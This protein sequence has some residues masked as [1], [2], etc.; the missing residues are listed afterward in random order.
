MKNKTKLTIGLFIA[1]VMIANMFV[2]AMKIFAS[3]PQNDVGYALIQINGATLSGT[4]GGS[5]VT[6]T[7]EHGT[8]TITGTSLYIDGS[9]I[10]TQGEVSITTSPATDYTAQVWVNGSNK[11]TSATVSTSDLTIKTSA[12]Q[13]VP[14]TNVELVFNAEGENTGITGGPEIVNVSGTGSDEARVQVNE[15][16]TDSNKV[17]VTFGSLFIQKYTGTVTITSNDNAHVY[18][19][20]DYINYSDRDSWLNHYD[21]QT[22]SFTVEGVEKAADDTYDVVVNVVDNNNVFIGNF[23]WTSDP[24]QVD[25]DTYVAHSKIELVKVSYERNGSTVSKTVNQLIDLGVREWGPGNSS[26]EYTDGDV[27]YAFATELNGNAVNYDDAELVVP[28][29]ARVTMKITPEYGYQVTS[30]TINGDDVV[31]GDNV[32]EFTFPVYAGNFHLGAEVTEVPN[33]VDPVSEKV[34]DGT[35]EI[36][37]DE[38]NS[39]SVVLAVND[40]E[41]ENDRIT[42]FEEYAEGYDISSYLSIELHQVI[43]KGTS[44]DVWDEQIGKEKDLKT[45]A[46]IT[47][48]LE[49]GVDGD[50]IAI[51][52]QKEDGTFEIIPATYDAETNTIT[53][54]TASFSNY[55]IV[56]KESTNN[57]RLVSM[58]VIFDFRKLIFLSKSFPISLLKSACLL[59]DL[60]NSS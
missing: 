56:S 21:H 31:T 22:V 30:F 1:I 14:P 37:N 24:E 48:Q 38:I 32:S 27:E 17:D 11:G 40:A 19:V 55:A 44:E 39:G 4:D 18:D 3:A 53:F 58:G 60:F 50:E 25:R 13:N 47:L 59:F 20:S 8:A 52:H 35:I 43:Y 54:E 36:A 10:Y 2:P 41:L 15:S 33:V 29:G 28:E 12:E 26:H 57:L 51:V 7:A 34:K 16:L 9:I 45:P 49:E 46:T 42:N 23:Q 6:A 5:T